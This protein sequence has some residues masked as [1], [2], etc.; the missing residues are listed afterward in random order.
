MLHFSCW[1]FNCKSAETAPDFHC[2]AELSRVWSS[3]FTTSQTHVTCALWHVTWHAGVTCALCCR[4]F[5][6]VVI[7]RCNITNSCDMC[8]MF[9][10]LLVWHVLYV[11]EHSRLWSSNVATSQT[12]VTCALCF[13]TCWCDMCFMLQNIPECGHLALQ[14]HMLEPIQRVPRYELLLRG[15]LYVVLSISK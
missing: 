4:T 12:R 3:C 2:V 6:S 13:V 8:F 10:H 14:H 7:W 5:L 15:L 11:A 9:H 1:Q